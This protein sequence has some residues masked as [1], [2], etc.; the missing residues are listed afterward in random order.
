[1]I[2]NV[3]LKKFLKTSVFKPLT[4]INK[5]LPKDDKIILLHISN[6]GIR[7]NLKPIKDYLIKHEMYK[8]YR[9]V[10]GIEHLKYADNDEKYVDYV[11]FFK[12]I[13]VFLRAKHVFYTAGQI[14]IKPSKNQIVIQMD[15]G[16]AAF[17]T[18][19]ALS[20]INNGDEF[21][22]TYI[23]APSK[24]YV[25]ILQR[26][27][28]CKEEN[29]VLCGEPMTDALFTKS[30]NYDLG[31]Y[32]KTILWMP[33]FRQS[34]YLN[35]N[36]SSESLLPMFNINEYVELNEELKKRDMQI[37]VKLHTAQNLDELKNVD[38]SKLTNL[39]IMSN[40]DFIKNGYEIYELL[41]DVDSL[42]GDY[43]SVSL[44]YLLLN[45]PLAFV[46]PDIE[47]YK[48]RRGFVFD[49]PEDY[50]AGHLIK[51]KKDF[52]KYLNDLSLG[53]DNYS[54]KRKLVKNSI[55]K[56]QDGHDTERVLKLSNIKVKDKRD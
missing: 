3:T 16:V 15:H 33:T 22:F 38:L 44:H 26:E 1:M 55:F 9:I 43:S 32:N 31:N 25:D 49:N 56:Y 14:P 47:E 7:H 40:D 11:T 10:C 34:K 46:I 39:K 21:F 28:L 12:S 48:E 52:Y 19:G 24:L 5:I 30:K 23:T 27:Y 2:K 45:K 37:I 36:D 13:L 54:E 17:K 4:I 29:V 6:L 20:N 53:I 50:M 18:G 41:K 8:D 35:Y 51:N 42:I